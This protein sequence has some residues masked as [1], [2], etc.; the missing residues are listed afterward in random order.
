MV[1]YELKLAWLTCCFF[2]LLCIRLLPTTP[3]KKRFHIFTAHFVY[4]LNIQT[5]AAVLGPQKSFFLKIWVIRIVLVFAAAPDWCVGCNLSR[6]RIVHLNNKNNQVENVFSS[7]ARST[8]GNRVGVK[9][10][11]FRRRRGKRKRLKSDRQNKHSSCRAS[12]CYRITFL[13]ICQTLTMIPYD[14]LLSFATQPVGRAY[15]GGRYR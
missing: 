10:A 12:T 2:S 3:F 7:A 5:Y 11:T 8:D 1:V 13:D 14:A 4:L 9:R 15:I 6:L